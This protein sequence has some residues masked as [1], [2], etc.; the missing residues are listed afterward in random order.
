MIPSV[1][2]SP[3]EQFEFKLSCPEFLLLD[4]GEIKGITLIAPEQLFHTPLVL[5]CF[6]P[7]VCLNPSSTTNV[8]EI[9]TGHI[10]LSNAVL[11][12]RKHWDDVPLVSDAYNVRNLCSS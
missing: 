2:T 3:A 1:K 7:V 10:N 11:T 5:M 4:A 6:S 8:K 9:N 12:W